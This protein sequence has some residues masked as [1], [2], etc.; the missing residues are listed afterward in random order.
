MAEG[1]Y[2]VGY[3]KP[4]AHSRFRPG[5]SG[6]PNGRP[7]KKKTNLH[8][9]FRVMLEK[10]VKI[11]HGNDV[12]SKPGSEVLIRRLI[13]KAMKAEQKPFRLFLLL[14]EKAGSL[15]DLSPRRSGTLTI[16]ENHLQAV[17]DEFAKR[18]FG[19]DAGDD[20]APTPAASKKPKPRKRRG[21][22]VPGN[23]LDIFKRVVDEKI[24]VPGSDGPITTGEAVFWANWKKALAG[25]ARAM[26][27]MIKFGL[28]HDHFK[29]LSDRK[30]AGGL[31]IVGA[32]P[33]TSEELD[34]LYPPDYKPRDDVLI[35]TNPQEYNGS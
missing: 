18:K 6:N 30:Q 27:N 12:S 28:N 17:R 3:G 24:T 26:D 22:E 9:T 19:H 4:P 5:Q 29:D 11:R 16:G 14:A 25:D 10:A 23:M 20:I 34:A 2:E 15:Q 35:V 31:L 32:R 33:R 8:D 21:Y 7:K 13:E 1:S